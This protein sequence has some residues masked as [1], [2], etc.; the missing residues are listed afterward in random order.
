M[1]WRRRYRK[2]EV[3]AEMPHRRYQKRKRRKK[4]TVPEARAE[5]ANARRVKVALGSADGAA[6]PKRSGAAR[7][8]GDVAARATREEGAALVNEQR[9][10]L[11]ENQREAL[12]ENDAAPQEENA[13]PQDE[14]NRSQRVVWEA[15]MLPGLRSQ[16]ILAAGLTQHQF[17]SQLRSQLL[18]GRE[19]SNFWQLSERLRQGLMQGMAPARAQQHLRSNQA[20]RN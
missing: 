8:G 20:G 7:Q 4:N 11:N 12:N 19:K 18:L 10:A 13:A 3:A 17:R 14:N 9:E 16:W 6:S 5:G 1:R 15:S 2:T